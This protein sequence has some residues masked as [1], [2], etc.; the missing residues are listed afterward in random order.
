MGA[1]SN[2]AGTVFWVLPWVLP[3]QSGSDYGF[4]HDFTTQDRDALYPA[5]H[6][7]PGDDGTFYGI[8]VNPSGGRARHSVRAAQLT[9]RHSSQWRGKADVEVQTRRA[10]LVRCPVTRP[11]SG[12]AR[13]ARARPERPAPGP[14][15]RR[16]QLRAPMPQKGRSRRRVVARSVCRRKSWGRR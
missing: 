6:L 15:A 7:V 10:A 16:C 2:N 5:A 14:P 8:T 4:L 1:A 9:A 11:Q 12:V 3:T 13:E